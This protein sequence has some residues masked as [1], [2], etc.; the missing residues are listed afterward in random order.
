MK[1]VAVINADLETTP[2]GTRSRLADELGGVPVLRRTVQRVARATLLDEVYVLCPTTQYE[3]CAAMLQGTTA[4]IERYNPVTAP[5]AQLVRT[6]R[7]WS[8]DAWRGGV[9]GTTH[10]DEFTDCGLIGGLLRT[11]PADAVLS[12]PPAAA[13]IDPELIDGMI[14][15][16]HEIAEGTRLVFTQA[17]PGVTGILL[18][19]SLVHE[20]ADKATPVGWVLSYKPDAPQKDLTTLPCCCEIPPEV[21]YAAGRL[22]ADTDRGTAI[23]AALLKEQPEPDAVDACRWL[24]AYEAEI[25]EPL[26]RE[27]EIELTT[28]DPY[29]RTLARP[30]GLWPQPRGPIAPEVVG[31]IAAELSRLDDSLMVLGGFGDA[32]RHPNFAAVLRGIREAPSPGVCGL[33]VRTAAVDLTDEHTDAMIECGVDILQATLDAWTAQTYCLIQSPHDPSAAD[34]DAVIDRLSRLASRRQDRTRVNPI[35]VPDMTKIKQNV[36]ELDDFHDGWLRKLGAVSI[37]GA[38]HHAG[39]TDDLSVIPMAPT[40]R[41]ACRRLRSRCVVLADGRVL[42]CDQDLHGR[43]AIGN[44]ADASLEDLWQSAE[45][46]RVRQA[47]REGCFDPTSLCA[48]CDDWHRP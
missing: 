11:R 13:A 40:A 36:Q 9:G 48:A 38:S 27:V 17:P 21:R 31:R 30:R 39:Q 22:V 41:V 44:L 7:K 2:L 47:H 24:T 23:L 4:R 46:R 20:L 18:D 29:P 19:A 1:I 25:C 12:I 3:R 34:L 14:R 26:P 16:R 10:F 15:H 45:C 35:V 8:L 37:T 32:L 42:L 6:A 5:W 43:H 28:D 33:A